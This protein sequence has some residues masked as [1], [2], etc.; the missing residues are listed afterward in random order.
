MKSMLTLALCL[1]IISAG[2]YAQTPTD[3]LNREVELNEV[4]VKAAP[5][6]NKADRKLLIP[7]AEQI[8]GSTNGVDLLRK[9]NIP[10]LLVSPVDQSIKLASNGKV[11]L[12]INGRSANEKEIQS[13]DPATVSR[14]EYHDNPS[15][16]YGDAEIVIDF[17]VKN[18]TSGGSYY[19][20]LTQGLNKGYNDVYNSLKLNYKKSEFSI[21]NSTQSRWNLGQWRDNTE[22]YTRA[23]GSRYERTEEGIPAGMDTFRDWLRLSYCFTES[24]KQMLWVGTSFYYDNVIHADYKGILTNHDTGERFNMQD[25]N[26]NKSSDI[27]LNLYYQRNIK[28]DQLVMVDVMGTVS[29][30]RSK[31]TYTE[32]LLDEDGNENATPYTDIYTHIKGK[33]YSLIANAVYEKSL[34]NKRITGGIRYEGNWSKSEYTVMNE[35]SRSNWNNVYAYGEYYHR[36]GEKVDITAGTGVL[37]YHNEAGNVSQS[38]CF[39]RPKVNLRYRPSK[40][41]TF[42]LSFYGYGHTPSV[43]QLTNVIQ[44]IDNTQLSIGNAELK[45]FA[46]YRTMLQYEFTRGAFYS[47]LRSTYNYQNKPIMEYKFIDGDNIISTYANHKNAHVLINELNL[48]LNNWKNWVTASTVFGH[49][50]SIMHGNDYTHTYSNFYM[51][52]YLEVSHWNWSLAFQYQ[53]NY[54]T[55]KGESLNG[56]ESLNLIGAMYKHKSCTFMLAVMNPFSNDFKVESENRNRYA[57]YNR[58]SYLKATQR[59]VA[60]GVRLNINWGRQHNSGTKRLNNSGS[61]ESVKAAGKG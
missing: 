58:T 20:N 25:L 38:S 55:F 33:S 31:R 16:R 19:A 9:L 34:T 29:P 53:T 46:S 41:S 11:D 13:I 7:N 60:L 6:I 18:P 5:V 32:Y 56:G 26:S 61:T 47:Y 42:R 57:G 2:A 21:S 22:Y 51:N 43:S 30:S 35:E 24:D 15:L 48:S 59:L 44:Q 52:G 17:I 23:D 36:F 1:T 4:V 37:Y 49:Y 14:V 27:T 40:S 12:R 45:N 28:K 8:K 10:S 39:L 3:T 50:R 54:N